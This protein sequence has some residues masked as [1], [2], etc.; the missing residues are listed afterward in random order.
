M[1][2]GIA[3]WKRFEQDVQALLGL[4]A[5]PNSGAR[6]H[7]PG[8]CVDNDLI[9]NR[10]PLQAE[11]KHTTHGSFP[12]QAK[13]LRQWARTAAGTGRRFVMPIR[14]EP[15][16]ESPLDVVVLLLDDFVEIVQRAKDAP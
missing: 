14:L 7:S 8:D 15:S 6:W 3:A 11:C 13:L 9:D 1:K 10:F 16:G 2:G 4:D 5:T 12:L